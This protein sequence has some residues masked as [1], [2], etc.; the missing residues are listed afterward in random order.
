MQRRQPIV[1]ASSFW[2]TP[3]SGRKSFIFNGLLVSLAGKI[4]ITK[5]LW[6]KYPESIT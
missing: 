1:A 5:G 4:F 6:L 2:G 3:F